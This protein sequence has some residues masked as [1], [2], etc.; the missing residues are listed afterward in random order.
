MEI[1]FFFQ[2]IYNGEIIINFYFLQR[3]IRLK[4]IG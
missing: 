1:F 3:E 4:I 2:I